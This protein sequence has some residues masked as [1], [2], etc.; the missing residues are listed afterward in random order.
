MGEIKKAFKLT[1]KLNLVDKSMKKKTIV[2]KDVI[3]ELN[4]TKEQ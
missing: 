4:S 2:W 1:K 3:E